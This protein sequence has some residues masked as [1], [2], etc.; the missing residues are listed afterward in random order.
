ME[1]Q[2]YTAGN[3]AV[4]VAIVAG[5]IILYILML[6]PDVRDDLLGESDLDGDSSTSYNDTPLLENPGR[7][8]YLKF[9]EREHTLPS[10]RIFATR[11]GESLRNI[12]GLYVKD[13]AFGDTV[14][15]VTFRTDLEK[16]ENLLLSFNVDKADGN[17]IILLNNRE[18]FNKPLVE[19]SPRPIELPY[20][21]L[22][23]DNTLTFMTNSPGI[24]FWRVHEYQLSNLIIT[25]DILDLSNSEA[26]QHFFITAQ[27]KDNM[28]KATIQFYPRCNTDDA[29][30][31][32][33]YL[34]EFL[35]YSTLADCGVINRF[36]VSDE[37]LFEGDNTL[38]F[39][40]DAGSYLIDNLEVRTDL[41]ELI[42]PVY[43]F[44]L[45]DDLFDVIDEDDLEDDELD[46]DYEVILTFR[47]PDREDK[48]ADVWVNGHK[49]F[50]DTDQL[51]Y[52]R[53]IDRY[54][55]HG[56]N[57]IEIVPKKRMDIQTLRVDVE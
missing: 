53:N 42:Y 17:L 35:V 31:L 57:S 46:E 27:E 49:F 34:N 23:I 44:E 13:G 18:I 55:F 50:L 51:V 25:A 22:E 54:V 2:G 24:A 56:T 40:T 48:L 19:G 45:E 32:S 12:N 20:D 10:F 38:R 52:E 28:E 9:D 26:E 47:F 16:A 1:K 11:Q 43:Y 15:E 30:K 21:Y 33:I 36:A 29:G 8:D 41:E 6:P 3:A 4:L 14:K 39:T 5:L 37:D 7:L